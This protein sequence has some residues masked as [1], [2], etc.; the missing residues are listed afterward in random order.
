M[1][2]VRVATVRYAGL[3]ALPPVWVGTLAL[4]VLFTALCSPGVLGH[5]APDGRQHRPSVRHRGSRPA[6]RG[7]AYYIEFDVDTYAAVT[8]DTIRRYADSIIPLDAEDLSIFY[9]IVSQR[10]AGGTFDARFTR[11]LVQDGTKPPLLIDREGVVFRNGSEYSLTPRALVQVDHFLT[12][13]FHSKQ[14]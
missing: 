6:A 3:P 5:R 7:T 2:P 1:L 13:G 14:R 9:S 8:P 4:S 12:R 10:R 11:L